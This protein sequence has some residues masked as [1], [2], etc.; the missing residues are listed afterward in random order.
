MGPCPSQQAPLTASSAPLSL[1]SPCPLCLLVPHSWGQSTDSTAQVR[2][3][4]GQPRLQTRQGP[5]LPCDGKVSL[6]CEIALSLSSRLFSLQCAATSEVLAT[7]PS[8]TPPG[9]LLLCGSSRAHRYYL[10]HLRV[11]SPQN[12]RSRFLNRRG[13]MIQQDQE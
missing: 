8:A 10:C 13:K 5:A 9:S 6:S 11:S 3:L 12:E 4:H 7:P 1:R 2:R